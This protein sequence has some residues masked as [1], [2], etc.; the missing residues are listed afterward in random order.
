MACSA[1]K[2]KGPMPAGVKYDSR[3]HRALF[4]EFYLNGAFCSHD[5]LIMSAKH[6]F[7]DAGKVLEDYD[8]LLDDM[9]AAVIAS[10]PTQI[11]KVRRAA[12]EHDEVYLYGGRL[13]RDVVRKILGS[14][15]YAGRI[16]DVVGP[17]R[18]CCDHFSALQGIF[19]D[20]SPEA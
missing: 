2:H 15:G 8:L 4:R 18:G 17:D 1:A 13:Y 20:M 7:V 11:A 14:V 9:R 5:M 12:W 6:G 3:Q 10:E 16:I 19:Y